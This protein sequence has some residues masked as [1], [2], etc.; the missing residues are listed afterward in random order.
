VK[1]AE[2]MIAL[3]ASEKQVLDQ[4]VVEH[5]RERAA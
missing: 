1:S 3:S 4:A 2:K 5:L